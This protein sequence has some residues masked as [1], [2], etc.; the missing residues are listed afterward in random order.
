M[1][2]TPTRQELYDE[3]AMQEAIDAGV[4]NGTLTVTNP[5]Q[6]P[7][8][9]IPDFASFK[10]KL[11]IP[12]SLPNAR[13]TSEDRSFKIK[14]DESQGSQVDKLKARRAEESAKGNSR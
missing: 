12:E 7:A 4:K 11:N 6:S 5:E 3:A 10:P 9:I 13:M 2:N 1:T 8:P 14:E